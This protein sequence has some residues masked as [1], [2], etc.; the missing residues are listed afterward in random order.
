M[1]VRYT[2]RGYEHCQLVQGTGHSRL[3]SL[4]CTA[5]YSPTTWMIADSAARCIHRAHQLLSKLCQ[6]FTVAV[7]GERPSQVQ[8]QFLDSNLHT[9][10]ADC[11]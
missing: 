10:H 4:Q 3:S 7:R 1:V 9:L 5:Y 6:H 2:P 8:M 11:I